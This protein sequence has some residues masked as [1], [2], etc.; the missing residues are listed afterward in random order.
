MTEEYEYLNKYERQI[1]V[2]LDS[3]RIGVSTKMIAES[4][5]IHWT[6]TKNNLKN[7]E[8]KDVVKKIKMG[9]KVLWELNFRD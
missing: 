1:I 8:K 9:N 4:L 6:T 2:L 7:L 3:A 5:N